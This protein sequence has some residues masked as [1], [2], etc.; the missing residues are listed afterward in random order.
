MSYQEDTPMK[1]P[2]CDQVVLP[3]S[4]S[5]DNCGATL[6][7]EPSSHSPEDDQ[8]HAAATVVGSLV[9]FCLTV[10][11]GLDKGKTVPIGEDEASIGRETDNTLVLLDPLVS[12]H[13]AAVRRKGENYEIEDLGSANGVLIDDARISGP[14]VLR[15]GDR[16]RLGDSELLFTLAS[17]AAGAVGASDP[18]VMIQEE[19]P[20]KPQP[21]THEVQGDHPIPPPP[22]PVTPG[23]A[24]PDTVDEPTSP[25]PQPAVQPTQRRDSG[26]G[27]WVALSCAAIVL[28]LL[29]LACLLFI[30]APRVTQVQ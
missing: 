27:R 26:V 9:P 6:A 24:Q 1:C 18:T 3:G 14:H 15:E 2:D 13:H 20:P 23:S 29:L 16:V 17:A 10:V 22:P 21:A 7:T 12:R 5:C 28:L 11:T 25:R 30:V 19:T 4:T 8:A